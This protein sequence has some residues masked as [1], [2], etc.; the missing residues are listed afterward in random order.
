MVISKTPLRA[1]FF[2]GG[3]DFKGYYENSRFGYGEV[4]STAVN[5]YVYITVLRKFDD[6]I[7][8][9]Y[10]Q[11]EIVDQVDDIKHNIIREALKMVGIEKGVEVIYSADLPL[12]TAGVGLASSS[13]IAVGALNALMAYKGEYVSPEH[14][15]RMACELEIGRLGNP[16]GIQDQYA[17]SYG[18]FR[19]YKFYSAGDV[20]AE[21]IL[22][23]SSVMTRLKSSLMLF[24]TGLTRDSSKIMREQTDTIAVKTAL[25]DSMV[26]DAERAYCSLCNGDPDSWGLALDVAWQKK[27]Q[28]ASGVSNPAID[29][30]YALA[31][32]AGA[33]GGKILGAGGGGFLL[34]YV[35]R[36]RQTDVQQALSAYRQIDF[37]FESA[38]SQIIFYD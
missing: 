14:L 8:V 31:R 26:E 29:K 18:G 33:V 1:S 15:A 13:A 35:P 16:I 32:T 34:L 2:G 21:P 30:M 11:N 17:V 7:R 38:G 24:Y 19:R 22:V 10:S 5:M 28:Y 12:A 25:L 36:E 27:R 37:Q 9:C 23:S 6:Q 20:S 4:L 3:T